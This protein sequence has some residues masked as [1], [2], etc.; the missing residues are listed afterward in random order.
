MM[1]ITSGIILGTYVGHKYYQR[2]NRKLFQQE[3]NTLQSWNID[4]KFKNDLLKI[5]G[6]KVTTSVSNNKVIEPQSSSHYVRFNDDNG[7]IISLDLN[8]VTPIH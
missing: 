6:T 7:S 3:L 1:A 5:H 8:D 2:S 4:Q